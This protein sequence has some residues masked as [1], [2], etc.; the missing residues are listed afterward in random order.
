MTQ[1]NEKTAAPKGGAP[2]NTTNADRTAKPASDGKKDNPATNRS[3]THTD[4]KGGIKEAP[5]TTRTTARTE[6]D[7]TGRKDAK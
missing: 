3:D 1:R 5:D 7:N 4:K 2:T 6:K